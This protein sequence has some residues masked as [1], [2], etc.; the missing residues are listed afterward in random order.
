MDD[1]QGLRPEMPLDEI[2][3]VAQKAGV[4]NIGIK[5]S[6]TIRDALAPAQKSSFDAPAKRGYWF[7]FV[8][9]VFRSETKESQNL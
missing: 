8:H 2:K 9:L 3:P 6:D 1:E 4:S 7:I 5:A